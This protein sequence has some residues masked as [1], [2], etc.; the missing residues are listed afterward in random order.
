MNLTHAYIPMGY[1]T[2]EILHNK[3]MKDT[4]VMDL[5][6]PNYVGEHYY[7]MPPQVIE[8]D[9]SELHFMQEDSIEMFFPW[10]N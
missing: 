7:D 1:D 9:P 2:Y 10:T 4:H 3:E 5:S 8:Y 6:G